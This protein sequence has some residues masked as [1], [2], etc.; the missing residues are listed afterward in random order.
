M[1]KKELKK[2][3]ETS[4]K[5]IVKIES[6]IA[7]FEAKIA[8]LERQ[9]FVLEETCCNKRGDIQSYPYPVMPWPNPGTP[10]QPGDIQVWYTTRTDD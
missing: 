6:N 4:N 9:L 5:E 3:I 7:K 1:K 10:W 8:K 2:R